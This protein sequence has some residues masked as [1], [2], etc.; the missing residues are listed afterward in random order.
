MFSSKKIKMFRLVAITLILSML[1]VACSDK[2]M[3]IPD[4]DITAI[5]ES[6]TLINYKNDYKEI[7]ESLPAFI[8]DE[9]KGVL[10]DETQQAYEA[11]NWYEEYKETLITIGDITSINHKSSYTIVVNFQEN[12][13]FSRSMTTI[14]TMKYKENEVY[15]I[16]TNSY[17]AN[18][19][20]PAF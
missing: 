7:I 19:A 1:L 9:A 6:L 11:N 2:G 15:E 3:N 13:L 14:I 8:S 4:H 10:L 12:N 18:L 5:A 16:H 17:S 20:P